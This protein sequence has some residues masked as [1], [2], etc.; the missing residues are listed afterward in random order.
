MRRWGI[1][2]IIASLLLWVWPAVSFAAEAAYFK[3]VD[4]SMQQ[5]V[6]TY[7][8]DRHRLY[9]FSGDNLWY[10]L[11]DKLE[12]LTA[13]GKQ[14]YL[15]ETMEKKAVLTCNITTTM[16]KGK[17]N[18]EEADRA[19]EVI[20]KGTAKYRLLFSNKNGDWIVKK[21]ELY[22]YLD[23]QGTKS[24]W[25]SSFWRYNPEGKDLPGPD[26]GWIF[27]SRDFRPNH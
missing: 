2:V 26:I 27:M 21:L 16:Y 20:W 7:G 24:L 6:A 1:T 4:E 9:H 14:Y 13:D 3:M 23:P 22:S 10:K 5:A 12:P 19:A 8:K 11:E 17:A 15:L 18:V 25:V